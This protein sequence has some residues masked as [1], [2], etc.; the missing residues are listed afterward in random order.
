MWFYCRLYR[1]AVTVE[2]EEVACEALDQMSPDDL[3]D[4]HVQMLIKKTIE[5]HIEAAEG[6]GMGEAGETLP[7]VRNHLETVIW[8]K[9]SRM[10]DPRE[11]IRSPE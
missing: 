1:I 5:P 6:A 10:S 9:L 7:H 3:K 2:D 8:P 4:C 11:S